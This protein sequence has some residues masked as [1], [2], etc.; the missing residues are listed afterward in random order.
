MPGSKQHS[1]EK[2]ERSS[3]SY[4]D[5]LALAC[6]Q[7]LTVT[8][9]WASVRTSS[10]V[11]YMF[12]HPHYGLQLQRGTNFCLGHY[13]RCLYKLF[14]HSFIEPCRVRDS[15]PCNRPLYLQRWHVLSARKRKKKNSSRTLSASVSDVTMCI[16]L[17]RQ[18]DNSRWTEGFGVK[19]SWEEDQYT[20]MERS[21]VVQETRRVGV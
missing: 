7:L 9:H 14:I 12:L 13:T 2:A 8:V 1:T 5:C 21:T 17:H 11:V 15:W 16:Q 10:R 3:E 4:C 19:G 6:S 20:G 18:R